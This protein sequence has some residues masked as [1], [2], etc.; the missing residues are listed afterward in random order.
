MAFGQ[1]PLDG[2]STPI[3][4]SS[5]VPDGTN[6]PLAVEGGPSK[7]TGGNSLAPVAVYQYDGY[8]VTQGTQADAA[9]TSNTA[10][11]SVVALLKGLWGFLNTLAGTVSA[12]KVQVS[13]TFWQTTQPVSGTV[14]ANAGTGS[15]NNASVGTDGSAVPTSSTL[16]GASDGT[17]LQGLI[18][19]SAANPNLKVALFNGANQQVGQKVMASSLP[20]AI[21]SDQSTLSTNIA[22]YNGA[23]VSATNTVLT[24]D[25]IRALIANGQGFRASTG[26]IATGAAN[27]FIGV[28]ARA[29]SLS[30]N[31]VIY[32]ITAISNASMVDGRIYHNAT[33]ANTDTGLSTNLLTA[34]VANQ[35]VGGAAPA[36]AVLNA[37]P[38]ATTETTGM[39][40]TGATQVGAFAVP[41]NTAWT[42]LNNGSQIWLPKSVDR[43]VSLYSLLI[44]SGQKAGYMIEWVEF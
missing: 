10:S 31:V 4:M 26:I 2:S 36:L 17:N 11:W 28:Q 7:T 29:Q 32:N 14:T 35:I 37:S 40:G 24:N 18:V 13:G 42:V 9:A 27:A 1:T 3:P 21:A 8:D 25:Q 5:A 23:A 33:G 20:V 19:Q 16:V 41:A 34:N 12:S 44:T 43:N 22:Q 38:A 39:G 30:V 15:Y 6:T